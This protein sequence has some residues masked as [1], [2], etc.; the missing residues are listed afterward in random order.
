[1]SEMNALGYV[2]VTD[3]VKANT[4]EDVSDAIQKI[5]DENPHRTI[6][7]PDGE[8]ILAKPICTP[9]NPENAVSIHL[10]D[11]ATLKAADGWNHTEAMVRLGASEPFNTIYVNGS[12]YCFK[13]G[14][15]DGNMVANGISIDSGRETMIRNVSIKHTF[16][17]LY[18]KKG[19]NSGSS[20]ADIE[21]VNIVGNNRPD[22][23]GVLVEGYDNTLTNMRIAAVQTGVKLI[24]G[25]NF[26][27]NIHPLYIF[28]YEY[29]GEDYMDYKDSVAF[30]NLN[31]S[32]WFD[33]CYSDQ[34]ATGFKLCEN[35]RSIIM[36]AFAMWYSPR[37]N[38]EVAFSVAGKFNASI[39]NPRVHFRPDTT[40]NA[41]LEGAT[42]GGYGF[43]ENPIFDKN[44]EHDKSY[45]EFVKG[46]IIW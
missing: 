5:I 29:L 38:K 6:Y 41:L 26:L 35:D 16:L 20:D 21:N 44:C 37:E 10:S 13:G 12:N 18:I 43:I 2:V 14:I 3:Y 34:M 39:T 36:N 25:G 42:E 19:A 23:M 46:N 1:M 7:F 17:G 15:I 31:P 22:S 45:E 11:F 33:Y 4:G 40:G 24:S 32:N 27:R 9:A 28:G 8:Y 30:W